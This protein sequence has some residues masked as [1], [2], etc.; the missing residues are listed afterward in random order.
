MKLA[1]SGRM[2]VGK[3][4]IAQILHEEHGFNRLSFADPIRSAVNISKAY[5]ADNLFPCEMTDFLL[6][7]TDEE[8]ARRMLPEWFNL[9]SLHTDVLLSDKKPREFLQ[10]WGSAMKLLDP[11]VFIRRVLEVAE[12]DVVVDDLRLSDEAWALV[13]DGWLLVRV[14]LS[15]QA[16][17]DRLWKTYPESYH[18][19]NHYTETDLDEW[20]GYDLKVHTECSKEHMPEL[21]ETMLGELRGMR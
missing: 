1:L 3:S 4:L 7:L 10:A 8:T 18:L 14:E 16:W 6:G 2:C 17:R 5:L 9:I 15:E 12:G 19:C 20:E 11:T 13:D 21:V